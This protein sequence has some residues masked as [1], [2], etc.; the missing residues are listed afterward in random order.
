[1][2]LT[3]PGARS[4]IWVGATPCMNTGW[5]KKG[6]RATCQERLEGIGG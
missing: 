6:L 5:G 2:K 1:M 4:Y 3:R